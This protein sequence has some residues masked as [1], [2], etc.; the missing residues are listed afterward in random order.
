MENATK[1]LLMAGGVLIAILILGALILMFNNLSSYQNTT[2]QGQAEA[3]IVEFNN[4]FVTYD[5]ENV[6][7]SDLYSLLNKVIDYNRRESTEGT[8]WSDSGQEV[9]FVPM[10]IIMKIQSNDLSQFSPDG[11]QRL[12]KLNSYTI[13]ANSNT[14][15]NSVK[16]TIDKLEKEYGSDSL[17]S[18]TTALTKIFLEGNPSTQEKIEAI[19]NFNSASKKIKIKLKSNSDSDVN[20]AWSTLQDYKYDIYSYYE[21]VQFKR[22]H[23]KCTGT[24]YDKQTGRIIEM[25]F[26]SIGTFN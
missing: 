14:F 12:I 10:K 25:D 19:N 6:R 11:E 5:N 22:L 20:T 16:N 4:Q 23:F 8:G 26:E 17:T 13:D 3:Q 9:R 1:A 15:E 2:Q 7:G 24:N 21:Y 18:L